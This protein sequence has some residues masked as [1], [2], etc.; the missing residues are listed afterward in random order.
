MTIG[1]SNCCQIPESRSNARFWLYHLLLAAVFFSPY[2]LFNHTFI[3]S[4]DMLNIDFPML[5]Q[6]KRSFL[7]GSVGLWNPHLLSGVS[8]FSYASAPI[9]APENWLP[10]FVPEQ[11]FFLVGSFLAFVKLWLVGVA[12]FYLFR[13]EL[14]SSRWAFFGSVTY[15]LCG[16]AL[17]A[18]LAHTILSLILYTTLG[19]YV[20]WTMHKRRA[21]LNYLYLALC[22]AATMSSANI[23]YS[24]YGAMLL[25]VLFIYRY[26]SLKKC[27]RRG[28]AWVVV[29]AAMMTAAMLFAVRLVPVWA[30]MQGTDRMA[31]R[32]LVDFRDYS[33]LL[34]RLFIPEVFG[35]QLYTTQQVFQGISTQQVMQPM[36]AGLHTHWA[37]PHF[38]GVLPVLLA[39][40]ALISDQDGRTNFWTAYVLVMIAVLVFIEPFE[41]MFRALFFPVY[42]RGALHMFLMVGFCMLIGHAG[43]NLEQRAGSFQLRPKQWLVLLGVLIGV[44][45]YGMAVWIPKI[46]G[47]VRLA[48]P[49]LIAVAVAVGLAVLGARK[50]PIAAG[51]IGILLAVAVAGAL[52]IVAATVNSVSPAHVSH[53][54]I[55]CASVIGLIALGLWNLPA[56]QDNESLRRRGRPVMIAVGVG[57]LLVTIWP[58]PSA[59]LRLPDLGETGLVVLLGLARFLTISAI[60]LGT[61]VLLVR[62]RISP[63]RIWPVFMLVLVFD[64]APADKVH[65]HLSI[66][67]FYPAGTPYPEPALV[68]DAN[69]RPITLDNKNYRVNNPNAMLGLPVYREL[70]GTTEILDSK[71]LIYGIRSYGGYYNAVSNRYARFVSA[72]CP[73]TKVEPGMCGFYANETGS[74]FL[75]LSGVR[76]DFDTEGGTVRIREG[77]MSR[78][79]LFRRFEVIEDANEA[80]ARLRSR[81]F[82]PLR[83]IVL[84]ADPGIESGGTNGPAAKVEYDDKTDSHI[85]V[86]VS[87]DSPSILFFGDTFHEG[88]QARIDGQERPVLGGDYSF[89]A[90]AVPAGESTVVLRFRPKVFQLGLAICALGGGVLIALTLVLYIF[91]HRIDPPRPAPEGPRRSIGSRLWSHVAGYW[92]VY[93]AIGVL[94]L[95]ACGQAALN[96]RHVPSIIAPGEL[97]V[98]GY[99]NFNIIRCRDKYYGL[100]WEEGAFYLRKVIRGEY[101]RC[102]VGDSIEEAK[103]RIDQLILAETHPRDVR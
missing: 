90:V 37:M 36:F 2:F 54:R 45:L 79:M 63:S 25:P 64:L 33:F 98:L 15:Q 30:E 1:D 57:L 40:W 41:T 24:C 51:R 86:R 11:Y 75:D 12:G 55:L 8:T 99:R 38:F 60:F 95:T 42:H 43:K 10:F 101:K 32:F 3:I 9:F 34:L 53:V 58:W 62:K 23:I 39:V 94:S 71:S 48:R 22:A 47:D 49:I 72:L 28:I 66:H 27:D 74:R 82:D 21:W 80:L 16:Y 70:Y 7:D 76:Y 17:W 6:A 100:A 50:W 87:A 103:R 77:A 84:D 29:P 102:V 14:G 67:P 83:S 18:T 68:V 78:F 65:Q 20:I 69:D 44:L 97:V 85:E 4:T 61:L 5:I 88:W 59:L 73:D 91:R 92:F 35:V 46:P 52:G 56:V 13:A 89:M 96:Y 81:Q 31:D 19:L 26:F 93:V